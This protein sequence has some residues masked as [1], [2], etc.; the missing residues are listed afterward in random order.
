[1]K[2]TVR[3]GT[4]HDA[5]AGAQKLSDINRNELI[6][7]FGDTWWDALKMVKDFLALGTAT[8]LDIDGEPAAIFGH[9]P[10]TQHQNARVTWFLATNAYFELGAR[11]VIMAR[12]YLDQLQNVYPG[13]TFYSLTNSDH[14]DVNRWF[15]LLGYRLTGGAPNYREYTLAP[16]RR[17]QRDAPGATW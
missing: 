3:T 10:H 4:I 7:K 14:P 2:M 16:K 5:Y 11:G 15:N 1:M 8:V 9:L 12:R 13:E 6:S 17:E